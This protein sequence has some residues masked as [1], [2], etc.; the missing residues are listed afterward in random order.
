MIV[1]KIIWGLLFRLFPCPT[2]TGLRSIGRPDADSPV[3][4]TC[5][6]DLTVRRLMKNLQKAGLDAWLLVG[7]SKGVNV[8][9]AAGAGEFNT[10]S[11]V[12]VVKTSRISEKVN[13]RTLIMPP[14]SGPSVNSVEVQKA[15]GWKTVWGP[16]RMQD[17]PV[18]ISNG[19]TRTES[20]KRATYSWSERMD[21]A[22]GSLFVI[23]LL[24]ALGFWIFGPGL[25]IN[26]L[27]IAAVAFLVFFTF[28]PLLP[29]KNGLIKALG[30]SALF[31]V[32]MFLDTLVFSKAIG[33]GSANGLIAMGATIIFGTELGGL[34]STMPSDLD[35]FLARMGIGK[36]G[37]IS[38]A[39]SIR[40]DLLNNLRRL[41][42]ERDKCIGCQTCTE[43][44]PLG[45]WEMDEEK[46]AMPAHLNGCT[47]CRACLTQCPSGA[48]T[49]ERTSNGV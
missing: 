16:V 29:G 32:V 33:F 47:A 46:R 13:H 42:Y 44:C 34:A 19:M 48:I 9:C 18:F 20:M 17:I 49:A 40:T 8:W 27:G 2:K 23:Y 35:P 36:I 41:T 31:A 3:L 4:V 45:V 7:D 37:N 38:F 10:H 30:V 21:T 5:N 28:C 14:L 15:T 24:G 22:L 26:Y 6:F 43:I 25:L 12:S 1:L 39:G 11:V